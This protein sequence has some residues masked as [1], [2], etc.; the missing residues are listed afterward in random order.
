MYGVECQI[1]KNGELW[2]A[3]WFDPRLDPSRPSRDMAIAWA[4]EERKVIEKAG[5]DAGFSMNCP[6]CGARLTYVRTEGGTNVYR[7]DRHGELMLPPGG[8]VRLVPQ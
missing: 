8:H 5:G 4:E 7:C 6:L 2:S 1:F 3:R